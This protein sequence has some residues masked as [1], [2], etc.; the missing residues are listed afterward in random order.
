MFQNRHAQ[1]ISKYHNRKSRKLFYR[2]LILIIGASL[3]AIAFAPGGLLRWK[4]IV[5]SARAQSDKPT[6]RVGATQSAAVTP[7][8]DQNTPLSA[9]AIDQIVALEAEKLNRTPAQQKIDSRLLQ[10][11]RESR[12]QKMTS[13]V[14][15]APANVGADTSGSVKVDIAADV[16]DDL[17]TRIEALGGQI[18]FPSWRYHTIRAQVSLSAIETVAGY[19]EVTF[20]EPAV[21]SITS[22]AGD[23]DS[24]G[25]APAAPTFI[26]ASRG[27]SLSRSTFAER[28]ARVRGKLIAAL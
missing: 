28:A 6:G 26:S 27:I 14:N 3:T 8:S 13:G 24:R 5:P 10:A 4:Q 16:S 21:G 19:G 25:L 12:G 23:V 15:L 20:V 1:S 7:Q 22:G 18:V 11:L 2:G 9:Q 17:I